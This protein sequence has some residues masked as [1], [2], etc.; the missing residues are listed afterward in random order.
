MSTTNK[1]RHRIIPAVFLVLLQE[2]NVLLQRR[3]NTGHEDGNYSLVGG[4]FEGNESATA[5][6]I[7]E[8]KEEIGIVLDPS[9][10]KLSYVL[11][12]KI[13]DERLDLFFIAKKWKGTPKICEPNKCDDLKYVSLTTLPINTT[14]YIAQALNDIKNNIIYGEFGW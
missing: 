9:E 5:V 4:H 13:D 1:N 10:L 2:G 8:A 7:R 3:K 14:A 11:H 6:L 12:K